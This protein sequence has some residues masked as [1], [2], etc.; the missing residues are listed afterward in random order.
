MCTGWAQ[1]GLTAKGKE[2]A[3][4]ARQ[5]LLPAGFW[6]M[7]VGFTHQLSSEAGK[8][9]Q[10]VFSLSLQLCGRV[11]PYSLDEPTL[12]QGQMPVST[13]MCCSLL[14]RNRPLQGL[15]LRQEF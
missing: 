4:Q 3:Q 10:L 12:H 13:S 11:L 7:L 1:D 14:F 15:P 6:K 8:L 9:L 2:Q 5:G